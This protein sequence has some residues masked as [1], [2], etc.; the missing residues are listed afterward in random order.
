MRTRVILFAGG[1]FVP[2]LAL[3]CLLLPL[4]VAAASCFTAPNG[5]VGWWPGDGNANDLTL[6]NNGTLQSGATANAAGQVGSAFN[7]DGTNNYVSIPDSANL[8]PTNLTIEAWVRFN[9]LDSAGS[10][11]AGQQYLVFKQNP[12]NANFEGFALTKSRSGGSDYFVFGVSSSAGVLAEAQGVTAISTGVWYHVAGVRSTNSIQVYVNG[13]L[14]AQTSVSFVQSY[15]NLPMYLGTSGQSYWDRKFAGRMDEVSL[16]TRALSGAEIASIYAA[17][18]SGKCKAVN[19]T[20][21]PQGQTVFASSNA[22][23]SVTASGFAPLTYQWR[24]NGANLPAGTSPTLNLSNVQ[25]GDA[26]GYTVVVSNVLGAVT[27]SVA[28]LTLYSPPAITVQPLSVTNILGGSASFNVT[29]SGSAT[30]IYQWQH[31]GTN[32][33][34]ANSSSFGIGSIQVQ[35]GG[36]YQVTV[37]NLAGVVTSSVATL[38]VQLPPTMTA[39]PQSATNIT[40]TTANFS[41]AASGAAPLGYQWRFNGSPLGDGGRITGASSTALAISGVVAGDAGNYSLVVSNVAGMTTSAVA[42]LT[43]WV[44]P[45]ISSQPQNATNVTGTTANFSATATGT[46]PLGYQWRFNGANLSNGGR[47]SGAT[48]TALA[49]SG[50]VAGDA[51]DYTLVVSNV[52]GVTT[53]A[54]ATLTVLIPPSVTSQPQSA[55]NV[56]GTTAN[57]SGAASGTSPLTYQWRLNGTKLTDDGRITGASSTALSVSSLTAGDAGNYTLVVSN[58]AGM[59]TSAVAT[60]TVWVPPAMTSQPQSATNIMGTTA[61]FGA[62][63]SGTAP[64]TYQWQYN[65][66]PLSNGGRVSGA[67]TTVLAISGLVA[68]DA[69]NYSLVVSNVAGMITSS[70][71]SLT[72]WVPPS[73]TSQPQSATNVTGTTANFSGTASGTAPLNYQW[74]YNGANLSDGG[75]ISGASSTALAISGLVAGDAGQYTLVVSNVAGVTTSSVATLT[76]WVPPAMTT[77]PLSATNITG[78]TANFSATASGTAPL[79]YQWQYNGAPLGDGGRISGASS[80]ALAISGVVSGDA[81]SYALVVSNVAG[82]VTSAVATLTVWVPPAMTSQPQSA[83]NISGTTANFNGTASGTAPL[84]YQWRFNGANL[85]EGGRISGASSTA[86]AI[87]GLTAGDAG[88]Y[89][90]VVSNVAGVVTSAVASLTVWVPPAVTL[91]PANATNV[92]GTTANFSATASGTAPLTYQWQYNGAPLSDGGR[93]SGA[94]STALAISGVTVGDAGNYSLVVSNV[95]GMITSSVAS[96]TVWVPPAMTSQPQSATNIAGTTANFSGTASGTDP[97]SYQWRFNGANLANGGRISGAASTSLAISNLS[98]G[99]AG[100]YSL[101]VSSVAGMVTSAVASLTVW[102]PPAIASQPQNATNVVGTTAN[103]GGSATGTAPLTYQWQYNGTALS[104]GGRISGANSSA[105]GISNVVTG[106]AGNYTLVV[107]NM[108]GMVTSAVATLTVWVPPAMASQPQ[109]A[110]NVTGTTAGFTAT[111]TGTAPLTYQWQYNGAPLSDGGRVSGA[112]ST[113]LA[114]SGVVTGDAGNYSLVVSNV[115]GTITSAGASL[116]VWVPPGITSQPQSATN[117]VGTTVNFT[118]AANG[119]EPL[120]YQWLYG[121]SKINN[122]GRVSGATSPTLTITNLITG[123]AGD[124]SVVITNSAGVITSAVASLT[125]W[126]PP[127]MTSQP[128][129]T[130]NVG[131]TTANFSATASGTAPLG[132]QWQFNGAPLTDGGRISGASSSALAISGLL[133]GDAGNYTLVVTNVAGAVTSSVASLTV[134]STPVMASQPQ[135][136]TNVTGT[137]ATFSATA[138]GTAPL[139][140]LWQYNGVPM[141]NGGRISGATSNVLS[142]SSVVTGDMGGYSLVVSNVAGMVTS[143]VASLTVWVPP[144]FSLQPQNLTNTSGTIATFSGA[145]TGTAPLSYQWRFNGVNLTNSARITGATSTSVSISNVAAGDAGPYTL[146]AVNSA[147]SATSSVATLIIA[148]APVIV[149]QPTNTA[150]PPGG[151]ASFTVAATGTPV[152][153]YQWRR[154]TTKLSNATSSSLT[155]SNLQS[156]NAGNYTVVITNLAGAVTSSV[157][158]LSVVGPHADWYIDNAAVGSSNN[159]TSWANAWTNFSNIIWGATGVKAGD[160]LY[161]SGGSTSKVYTNALIV[162]AAG[163]SNYPIVITLDA[164]NSNHNGKVTWDYDYL[165]DLDDAVAITCLKDYVTISGEVNG[166][167]NLVINNLR[168]YL[169]N[170][171]AVAIYADSTRGVVIDHVASTNC[172]NPIRLASSATQFRISNCI[173]Q[174]VRGDAAI[175]VAGCMGT[176]DANIICSNRFEMVL[177]WAVPPGGSGSYAGPDGIQCSDGVSIFGNYFVEHTTTNFTSTQHPDMIQNTG[178]NVKVYNNEFENVGDSVF[179]YDCWSDPEPHDIWIFNN[180][181]HITQAIDPYPEYFRLYSSGGNISTLVNLKIF[182][183]TF[184]DNSSWIPITFSNLKGKPGGAGNEFKNNLFYNCGNGTFMPLL[185]IEDNCGFTSD[186]FAFDANLYFNAVTEPFIYYGASYS[187]SAWVQKFEPN[188][189]TNMPTFVSYTPFGASNDLH[190]A[191]TDGGAANAGVDLSAY[192]SVDR[193]VITRPQGPAWDIGAYEYHGNGRALTNVAPTLSAIS[194]NLSDLDASRPFT[195]VQ[196]GSVA[197]YSCSVS[198]T[199]GDA[200]SWTWSYI[201]AGVGEFPYQSG[202]GSVATI[203][204]TYPANSAGSNYTWILRVSDGQTMAQATLP[205]TSVSGVRSL[206]N[207]TFEAENGILSGPFIV[208]NGCIYQTVA[209]GVSDGGRAEYDFVITNTGDYIVQGIIDAPKFGQNSFY[210]NID[211]EPQDPQMIWFSTITTNFDTRAVSWMG[212]GTCTSPQFSTPVFHLSAGSHQLIVRGRVP[213]AKLDRVSLVSVTLPVATTL[214]ISDLAYASAT[215]SGSV[216]PKGL[217]AQAYFAYGATTNY[218]KVTATVNVGSGTNAVGLGALISSLTQQAGYHYRMVAVNGNGSAYGNDM[219]FNTTSKPTLVGTQFS[220]SVL[221]YNGYIYYLDCK[222]NLSDPN[223][224]NVNSVIGD[225]TTKT[226]VDP[227]ATGPQRFYRIRVVPNPG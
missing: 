132:Y 104:D 149:T 80:S 137:T 143:S 36:S 162:G 204:Y 52:A 50:I 6:T 7:F 49:I 163:I 27:S 183:N 179:D 78:M 16:Y 59:V 174:G 105:L 53:S 191:D 18:A 184:M 68:G 38:T 57:F 147:G 227:N 21:Q 217:S 202:T 35:D 60:L 66:A 41:A 226:L 209:S 79:S 64:L 113:A 108:A 97:L 4:K 131:G 176:W 69:G 39:Q 15:T 98:A 92:T 33:P 24:L 12:R 76:V 81:G 102:V 148:G 37:S 206:S 101:V 187:A 40:G 172:N 221:T 182:N 154:G 151:S 207:L 213:F 22:T 178:N 106:D 116:T 225:G 17:G 62:T 14:E 129:S 196:A 127:A 158:V 44:P 146:V 175:A 161:I 63:A 189:R 186:S 211:A 103:F 145:A 26:G 165:G 29:A 86:L 122:G 166:Q 136:T 19:I 159:G 96:L 185:Y 100:S 110:T 75:R 67:S 99:D 195:Q 28:V 70:V 91:Q 156:S 222:I 170:S 123:F 84:N 167:C 120:T 90:L 2:S 126:V 164:A 181:F 11:S 212:A 133:P 117:I 119:T 73:I 20:S 3:L 135:S 220:V 210:V 74:R 9:S 190:L 201:R 128:A 45:V 199:N 205:V 89:T 82:M 65:G 87:S 144:S 219:V 124:Y 118:V 192:F 48:S 42:T 152:L 214:P 58:V 160:T 216:N 193:E 203:S 223:W 130:T 142:V 141:A 208:T 32:L 139:T 157:A 95:A 88:N 8:R 71:A 1:W 25:S 173:L 10:A 134:I 46:A 177:N 155:L 56:A 30:L 83:T 138:N 5:L 54:V 43:V 125:V 34:G 198:D 121:S 188:G 218:G 194:Q 109:S 168:N 31:E 55:T 150:G 197:Q 111:A 51:G 200:L 215:L 224:T 169:D 77:Q 114:I 72:V 153:S 171:S 180:L 115:A 107:S 61:N 23:F 47:I 13:T 140:Y 112:S 85:S 93:I 94:S